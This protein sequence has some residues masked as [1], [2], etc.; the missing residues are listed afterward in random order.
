MRLFSPLLAIV[1]CL[2][3]S[4]AA[5][6]QIAPGVELVRG[7]FAAGRQPDGNSVV[8]GARNG[9]IVVDTGRHAEHA[10]RVLD[11]VAATRQPLRAIVN[12]HWHLD[13]VSNNP[14][15]LTAHPDARVYASGAIE[16]AMRG[17][18]ARYRADLERA[19]A[20]ERD[21]GVR[22]GFEAERARIDAGSALFPDERIAASGARRLAGRQL[23][24]VLEPAPAV[25]AGDVWVFDPSSRVLVAGDLV[26]L[27]VPFLD[28]ACPAGWSAALARIAAKQF[29]VLVPGHGE[30]MTRAQF[31]TWRGA[32]TQLLACA[33][34]TA[35]A[36]DCASQ[37][38]AS[39]G[40]LLPPHEH[41]RARSMLDYYFAR[42]LRGDAAANARLCAG[43]S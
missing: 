28:T 4:L 21:A 27:P 32:F 34:G 24:I 9:T 12:T 36:S 35:P 29:D 22:A 38:I 14:A 18:L 5:A 33:S 3:T 20:A 39:L 31:A 43:E 16:P 8:I 23:E 7:E 15:L 26:T 1:C 41:A 13:H 6:Q 25:T 30:P 2:A 11:A 40:P 42:H 19:I 17:F 10:G 37:W